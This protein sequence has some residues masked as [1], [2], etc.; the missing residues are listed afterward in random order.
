MHFVCLI[1]VNK[2]KITKCGLIIISVVIPHFN[3][4][5]NISTSH[6]PP[7]TEANLV[8]TRIEDGKL[9]YERRWYHRG[10]PVYVE[11]MEMSRFGANIAA[12]GT[13]VVSIIDFVIIL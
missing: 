10:Q 2:K 13:E 9:W 4:P 8:E 11:G 12:I 6:V 1:V 5:V 7:S 3:N